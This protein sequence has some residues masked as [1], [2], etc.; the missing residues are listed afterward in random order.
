MKQRRN[1]KGLWMRLAVLGFLILLPSSALAS[2]LSV[3][4][5]DMLEKSELIFEGKVVSVNQNA[6]PAAKLP[7][8]CITFEVVEILKGSR[9]GEAIDLCFLGGTRGK[10][11]MKVP[12]IKYPEMAENGI[13]FIG[14]ES[15]K[16]NPIFGWE[17]GHF[18][19]R[20][21][22]ASA[23]SYVT[24]SGERPITGM[25]L[26]GEKTGGLSRGVAEGVATAVPQQLFSEGLIVDQF[27]QE[28]R[29]LLGDH[30]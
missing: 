22:P 16:V 17:Q 8:T 7:H 29:L 25:K 21:D 18:I 30:Q 1:R 28:L 12:E 6:F 11:I 14:R 13:Y 20:K 9:S 5:G 19:I 24:S 26:A 3:S 15:S 4:F 23:K 10:L 27:K 2:I